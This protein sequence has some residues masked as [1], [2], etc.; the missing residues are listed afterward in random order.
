MIVL[1][2]RTTQLPSNSVE[3]GSGKVG[4]KIANDLNNCTTFSTTIS[5]SKSHLLF[6]PYLKR[7]VNASRDNI[8]F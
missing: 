2:T 7:S 4:E 1:W 8:F 5:L 6:V 3:T